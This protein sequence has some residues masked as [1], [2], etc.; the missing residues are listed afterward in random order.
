[1]P[2]HRCAVLLFLSCFAS[3]ALAQ[4][5]GPQTSFLT[6]V[7]LHS[8]T[9]VS[10]QSDSNFRFGQTLIG[11]ADIE[12]SSWLLNYAYRFAAGERFAQLS[13]LAGYQDIGASGDLGLEPDQLVPVAVG[14]AGV[15]DPLLTFRLGLL[16]APAL[17][18]AEWLLAEKGFQLYLE[19]GARLPWGDYSSERLLNPG[20]NRHSL[21]LA[22]P[23]VIPIDR[24]RQKTFLEIRP[25]TVWFSDNNDA[26]GAAERLSQDPLYII[27]L[28]LSRFWTSRFWASLGVQAQ[29]GGETIVDGRPSGNRLDQYFGEAALGYAFNRDVALS[30][31]YGRIFGSSND[32]RGEVWRLRL[33]LAF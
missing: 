28:Q 5:V 4:G 19:V 26:P 32:T 24:A 10:M 18:P 6:P 11:R 8:L 31:T 20:F 33:L 1:M 27:E 29:W 13:V 2:V 16:G 23:M 9:T 3:G 25:E 7:G 14:R 21:S 30:G 22:L 17:S 12:T 15:T